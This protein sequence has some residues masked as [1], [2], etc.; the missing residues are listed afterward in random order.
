MNINISVLQFMALIPLKLSNSYMCKVWQIHFYKYH[1][2]YSNY[3]DRPICN[4][5]FCIQWLALN[6][7]VLPMNFM[8]MF[9]VCSVRLTQCLLQYFLHP[10]EPRTSY[11]REN[12]WV[13][14]MQF[15]WSKPQSGA[16]PGSATEQG[17]EKQNT[18]Q[19]PSL[20]RIVK[21]ERT[22]RVNKW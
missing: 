13:K 11:T 4:S 7:K 6:A 1:A 9:P 17:L 19:V 21:I 22:L 8:V 10:T 20:T 15:V 2:R 16:W 14:R 18:L 3:R 12:R 5:H